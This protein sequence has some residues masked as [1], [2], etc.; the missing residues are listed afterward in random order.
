MRTLLLVRFVP[1]GPDADEQHWTLIAAT[2]EILKRSF[3]PMC[4]A[5]CWFTFWVNLVVTPPTQYQEWRFGS[6]NG[7]TDLVWK[8]EDLSIRPYFDPRFYCTPARLRTMTWCIMFCALEC[9]FWLWLAEVEKYRI[10]KVLFF[11]RN[12]S[13]NKFC[14][15]DW[16]QHGPKEDQ[17]S[18]RE[19]KPPS[20]ALAEIAREM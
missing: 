14:H 10:V 6:K 19:K 8:T 4:I 11:L 9:I 13:W 5:L 1:C 18:E 7:D 2:R 3:G 16:E 20:V 15:S 17:E 12:C